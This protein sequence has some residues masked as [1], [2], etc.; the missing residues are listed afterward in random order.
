[1]R[2]GIN[3]SAELVAG[4]APTHGVDGPVVGAGFTPAR[5]DFLNRK[6]AHIRSL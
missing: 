4:P 6:I 2:A 1:M 5:V 3:G